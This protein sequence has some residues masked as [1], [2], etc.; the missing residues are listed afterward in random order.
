MRVL[1]SSALGWM[2]GIL[3]QGALAP[4]LVA[5]ALV[6]AGAVG[7]FLVARRGRWIAALGLGALSAAA[8]TPPPAPPPGAQVFTGEIARPVEPLADGRRVEVAVDGG[9][10][11]LVYD[12]G[13]AFLL[14][15]D[16][17]RF[18]GVA[19]IPRGYW[20]EGA[21]DRERLFAA[22]GIDWE[23]DALRPGVAPSDEPPSWSVWR[24]AGIVRERAAVGLAA[25]SDGDGGALLAALVL[26]RRGGVS[27]KLE[28]EF[29]RAG[30]AHVLS[31]SGLH[32]AAAAAL[33]FAAARWA[34][35]RVP[36]LAGRLAA[37]RAAAL[38]ALPA[39]AAYTLVTGAEVATVRSLGCAAVVLGARILSRPAD[40]L[41]ALAVAALLILAAAPL[42]LY[43]A[44]FQLSFAAAGALALVARRL[45][46]NRALALIGASAAATLATAPL[47]ALHFNVVQPAGLITNLVIVPLAEV[48]VL[49]IGLLA[50]GVAVLSPAAAAPFT[51]LAGWA[52]AGLAE[53]VGLCARVAPSID[54]PPPTAIELVL[55]GLAVVAVLVW[56]WRRGA[57]AL[58]AAF[59]VCF[60]IESWLTVA[61]P[62][63]REGAVVTFLDVGQG[64]AA[65]IEAPHGQTWLVDAG[66]RLFGAGRVGSDPGEQATLRFLTAHRVRRLDL[67]VV[68]HP[69][70]DHYGGLAAVAAHI[71]IAEM[72]ISGDDPGD[73]RW[74]RLV[75]DLAAHG[76]RVVRAAPGTTRISRGA[77]LEV[78]G[79]GPDPDRSVNDNSLVARLTVGGRRVLFAGDLEAP[80][81]AAL[82]ASG[83]AEVAADVVKVAHHGSKTSSSPGFVAATHPALAVVSCGAHNHFG[84]PNPGVI[85]AWTA[86]GAAVVRTDRQ[87]AVAVTLGP[88]GSL[89]WRTWR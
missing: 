58:L 69:H 13:S 30:V 78:L 6:A 54:V 62:A 8:G 57:L 68:S 9:A 18:S 60:A 79:G 80:G 38:V 67:V 43:D 73:A 61:A 76:T 66:G 10:R 51:A 56:P 17:V 22:R 48:V 2:A 49:P 83:G 3:L 82:V 16:R 40:S 42:A 26:G 70:P 88:D 23:I 84:F 46:R 20:D 12:G 75:A 59:A 47:T 71:P 34:W 44:S 14:P 77:R 25:A 81:E 36:R 74:N 45:P 4:A 29:R 37:D 65:V 50:A 15:G 55:F 87:G 72:W 19:H 27:E 11:A 52:A 85:S 41:T 1:C 7:L 35:L 39:A 24:A 64:D 5:S 21:F 89:S 86:A 63:R 28:D 53:L 32:L 31:V 33:F